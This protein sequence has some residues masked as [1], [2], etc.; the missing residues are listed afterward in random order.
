[1]VVA[2]IKDISTKTSLLILSEKKTFMYNA[3]IPPISRQGPWRCELGEDGGKS[4]S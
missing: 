2:A 1:M 3:A 4:D